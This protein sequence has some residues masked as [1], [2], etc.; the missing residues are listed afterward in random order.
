[1]SSSFSAWPTSTLQASSTTCSPVSKSPNDKHLLSEQCEQA[2]TTTRRHFTGMQVVRAQICDCRGSSGAQ[3]SET[4]HTTCSV[5]RIAHETERPCRPD[6]SRNNFCII[7]FPELAFVPIIPIVKYS[8]DSDQRWWHS[9]RYS[10]VPNR[11]F[12]NR[13]QQPSR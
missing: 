13:T 8:L 1:M 12:N 3:S 10:S 6:N 9:T 11:R 7:Q 2:E 5:R 4:W